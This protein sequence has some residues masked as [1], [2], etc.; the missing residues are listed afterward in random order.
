[1]LKWLKIF[2]KKDYMSFDEFIKVG[3]FKDD[4][5]FQQKARKTRLK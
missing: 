1:M 4:F 3:Q 2:G 5:A